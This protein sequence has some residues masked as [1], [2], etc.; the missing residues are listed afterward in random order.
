[1]T[2][3]RLDETKQDVPISDVLTLL[4]LKAGQSKSEAK[5]L[6]TQGAVRIDGTIVTDY[7]Q[8]IDK[9]RV[10]LQIGKK[11]DQEIEVSNGT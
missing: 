7:F 3:T 5:R 9:P 1:M 2:M 10:R 8:E 4:H 11:F 6:V